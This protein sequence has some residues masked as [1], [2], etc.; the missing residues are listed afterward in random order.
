MLTCCEIHAANDLCLEYF[1]DE[2]TD[3]VS[4]MMSWL[5]GRKDGCNIAGALSSDDAG[6]EKQE[7]WPLMEMQMKL[8]AA[9]SGAVGGHKTANPIAPDDDD[10]TSNAPPSFHYVP[11]A[12]PM[13]V[14][15]SKFSGSKM[16]L[17]TLKKCHGEQ[18]IY[19]LH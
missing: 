4:E 5:A 13:R 19:W 1:V 15:K 2:F 10:E 6:D 14:T 8:R 11:A 9:G 17:S 12:F 18:G 16:V 7:Q 3:S